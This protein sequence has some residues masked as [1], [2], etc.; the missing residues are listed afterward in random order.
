MGRKMKT[1]ISKNNLCFYKNGRFKERKVRNQKN[2][3]EKI[4]M[5][6]NQ[7]KWKN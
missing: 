4:G 5:R 1:M 7:K 6:I 3:N 2:V